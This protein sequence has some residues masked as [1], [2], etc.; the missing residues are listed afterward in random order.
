[1]KIENI[2]LEHDLIGAINSRIRSKDVD[3]NNAEQ[4][5][6]HMKKFAREY[7]K[8]LVDELLEK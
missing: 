4:V 2:K 1:M 5:E 8:M 7:P 3:W 6:T